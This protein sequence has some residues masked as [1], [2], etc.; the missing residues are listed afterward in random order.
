MEID[1]DER[2]GCLV[3]ERKND[4]HLFPVAPYTSGEGLPYAPVDWPCPGDKWR[5][6]V[7]KRTVASGEHF[8]DRHLYLPERLQGKNKG[9]GFVSKVS[10]EQYVRTYPGADVKAFFDSFSWK[11]P[12]KSPSESKGWLQFLCMCCTQKFCP[13][14]KICSYFLHQE[15]IAVASSSCTKNFDAMLGD[16]MH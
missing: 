13:P 1:K 15:K 3:D 2:K 6:K 8:W 10:V 7:G 4:L 5:W 14:T 16:I 9:R 12:Y 11:I